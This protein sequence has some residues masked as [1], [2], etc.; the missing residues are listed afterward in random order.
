MLSLANGVRQPF[1]VPLQNCPHAPGIHAL[2]SQFLGTRM[3]TRAEERAA[4]KLGAVNIFLNA[5]RSG[6]MQPN[7]AAFIA[8]F[9][10]PE[11]SFAV[12]LPKIADLEP[13][14][15]GKPDAG[16]E[17]QLDDGPVAVIQHGF[18]PR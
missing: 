6:I 15:S 10:Q 18:A 5:L 9:L 2:V 12:L 13:A 3:T 4:R 11:A 14:A 8:F 1:Q 7:R 17:V 16:I